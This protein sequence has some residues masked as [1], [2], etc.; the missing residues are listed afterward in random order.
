MTT[1]RRDDTPGG[2]AALVLASFGLRLAVIDVQARLHDRF[3]EHSRSTY[4]SMVS[5]L[6]RVALIPVL[7]GAGAVM[8]GLGGRGIGLLALCLCLAL[9]IRWCAARA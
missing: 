2:V 8:S 1:L 5:T 4:D 7:L 6:A 3:P 9:S